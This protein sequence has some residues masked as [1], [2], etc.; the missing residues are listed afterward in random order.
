MQ[1]Q[2][3]GVGGPDG[4]GLAGGADLSCRVRLLGN[5]MSRPPLQFV[6]HQAASLTSWAGL[7]SEPPPSGRLG[8][9]MSM[10]HAASPSDMRNRH[11]MYPVHHD[12][13][14]T[15]L[16]VEVRPHIPHHAPVIPHADDRL[17]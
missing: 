12:L 13:D 15:L 10:H 1:C 8:S 7:P 4:K 17:V 14:T 2:S 5:A 9:F 16:L 11:I 3:L 6:L